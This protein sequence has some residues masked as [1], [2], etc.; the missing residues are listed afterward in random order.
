MARYKV[1]DRGPRSLPVVLDAQLLPGSF[2][3]ALDYLIDHELDL[4]GLVSP[5]SISMAS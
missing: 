5:F 2:E 4:S 1:V 3:F